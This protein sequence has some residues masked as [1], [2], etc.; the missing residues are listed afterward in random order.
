M[1]VA[2]VIER[3][4]PWRGGA[5]T[6]TMQFAHYL[7][8]DGCR[9][10]VLTTSD[11]PSTPEL[12]IVPVRA[13]RTFRSARTL[14]FSRR[15]AIY[16]R[17][18]PFDIVHCITPCLSADVYQP[19]GGTI[20]E[21]LERN[22]SIRRTLVSR[23]AK[24]VGQA[25]NVKYHMLAAME[26]RLLTRKPAPW[27]I[28]ISGYVAGQLQKH[29][30][31]DPGRIAHVFNG[32][33]PDP[34]PVP[35][36]QLDRT[37]VRRQYGIGRDALVVLCVAHNF[38]LKGVAKLIEAISRPAGRDFHAVIVGR[39]NPAPYARLSE[40]LGVAPRVTFSGPTT[41]ISAFFHAADV[42]AHPTY[43]D[44]CSRVV[45][46][47]MAAGLP[48]VT[49]RYN[50]AAER[51]SDGVQGY[52]VDSPNDVD[53]LADRLGRLADSAHREACAA[54]APAAVA[55]CSMEHHARE[56]RALYERILAERSGSPVRPAQRGEQRTCT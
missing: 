3:I 14:F 49:T 17:A 23:G 21:T 24:R 43:Y 33:D 34:T 1:N 29:Y 18:N 9:V 10:S 27:V 7:A 11:M 26:K 55:G 36:R 47:A 5:E 52:V 12:T 45:L 41:R 28:A 16:T 50:G 54:A 56:V 38:K 48:A 46:E 40:R 44:P 32:V 37:V 51:I 42:L 6:S 31:F 15:A 22:A 13:S 53:A 30:R 19:R 35:E 2:L 4:E 39:D 25:F 8:R 20:P